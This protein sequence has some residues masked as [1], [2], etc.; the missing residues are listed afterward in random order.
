[1][2]ESLIP[3]PPNHPAQNPFVAPKLPSIFHLDLTSPSPIKP[4]GVV[5]P[6]QESTPSKLVDLQ[7][8]TKEFS[9]KATQLSERIEKVQEVL[10]NLPGKFF[11]AVPLDGGLLAFSRYHGEWQLTH[12]MSALPIPLAASAASAAND[13]S[14][15]TAATIQ[16][17]ARAAYVLPTLIEALAQQAS[18]QL[19]RVNEGLEAIEGIPF[20]K[21]IL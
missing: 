5:A 9:K 16:I 2:P 8:R 19:E 14:P 13:F 11:A 6:T 21:E 4:P 3:G 18:E 20:L 7:E 12:A 15:L 10:Q 17:K 1:M